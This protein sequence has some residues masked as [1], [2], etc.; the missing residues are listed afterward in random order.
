MLLTLQLLIKDPHTET[1]NQGVQPF[2]SR[3]CKQINQRAQNKRETPQ[4]IT[5]HPSQDNLCEEADVAF[6]STH[7][8]LRVYV[9]RFPGH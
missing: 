8:H 1:T 5:I 9:G 4:K 2:E 3:L 6:N 7:C